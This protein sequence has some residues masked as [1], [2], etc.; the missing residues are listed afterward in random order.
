MGNIRIFYHVSVAVRDIEDESILKDLDLPDCEFIGKSNSDAFAEESRERYL[1]RVESGKPLKNL[2]KKL[3]EILP[4]K[5]FIYTHP[6]PAERRK[7]GLF[8]G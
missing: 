5:V 3:G 1:F 8:L 4:K 6:I 7:M 2:T